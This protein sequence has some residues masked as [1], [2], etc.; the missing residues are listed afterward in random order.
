ML[1]WH[2][3]PSTA[4]FDKRNTALI[5]VRNTSVETHSSES[6]NQSFPTQQGNVKTN[7]QQAGY[8]KSIHSNYDSSCRISGKNRFD[9][10]WLESLMF[11]DWFRIL[12]FFFKFGLVEMLSLRGHVFSESCLS[13]HGV[14]WS[15]WSMLFWRPQR[16]TGCLEMPTVDCVMCWE[17]RKL[18]QSCHCEWKQQ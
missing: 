8:T 11:S 14:A 2:T 18:L 17:T 5:V 13:S 4:G 15:K 1:C 12:G 16:F 6:L 7:N 10:Y 3:P 9:C